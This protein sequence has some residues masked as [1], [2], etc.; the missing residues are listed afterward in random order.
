VLFDP[1]EGELEKRLAS[2]GLAARSVGVETVDKKMT[3]PQ[4]AAL[5]RQ[6]FR[7]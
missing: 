3:A 5:V 6:H 1:G 4:I 2:K 7:K